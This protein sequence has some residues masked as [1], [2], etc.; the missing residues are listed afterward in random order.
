[1]ESIL[2][3]EI[4]YRNLLSSV[5]KETAGKP[6]RRGIRTFRDHTINRP[7]RFQSFYKELLHNL[8]PDTKETDEIFAEIEFPEKPFPP[9]QFLYTTEHLPPETSAELILYELLEIERCRLMGLTTEKVHKSNH[10]DDRFYFL[11]LTLRKWTDYL[12]DL[13]KSEHMM[14]EE[15]GTRKRLTTFLRKLLLV[16]ICDLSERYAGLNLNES[17]TPEEIYPMLL[18]QK[19]TEEPEIFMT[20]ALLEIKR[21]ELAYSIVENGPSEAD[22]LNELEELKKAAGQKGHSLIP[23]V[24]QTVHHL[25]NVIFLTFLKNRDTG[26][27]WGQWLSDTEAAAAAVYKTRNEVLE[28]MEEDIEGAMET[29]WMI[30]QNM[31][32]YLN[33]GLEKAGEKSAVHQ[34][35]SEIDD[36]DQF[37]FQGTLS[38]R[39]Q[40][41][42]KNRQNEGSNP[43]LDQAGEK[44]MPKER[45]YTYLHL[46]NRTTRANF[47]KDAGFRYVQLTP[48]KELVYL[49]DVEKYVRNNTKRYGKKE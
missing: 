26:E 49:E 9:D 41:G 12:T 7:E 4:I 42:S 27:E 2:L 44:F 15:S 19:T 47:L 14:P 32:P 20:P 48:Q 17:Y 35:V 5:E 22:Y 29:L 1:M 6:S 43:F 10:K 11:T 33:A 25:E 3:E 18:N 13:Q 24:R 16:L 45:L 36:M 37:F 21:K 40:T 23:A 46:E 30:R 31:L 39:L 8:I 38:G 34:F 28:Q